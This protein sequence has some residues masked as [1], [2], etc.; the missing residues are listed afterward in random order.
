MV[1]FIIIFFFRKLIRLNSWR[2]F[3]LFPIFFLF[4]TFFP[5]I[6]RTSFKSYWRHNHIYFIRLLSC[7]Q[8][9]LQL[10]INIF[11][12]IHLFFVCDTSKSK[13]ILQYNAYLK[14]N[15]KRKKK[16]VFTYFVRTWISN[17]FSYF[18]ITRAFVVL[19]T[20]KRYHFLDCWLLTH[21]FI[22]SLNA[23]FNKSRKMR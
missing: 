10:V 12:S 3:L 9:A 19:Y 18:I 15:K 5:R 7:Y 6:K 20:Y 22:K 4:F 13:D 14:V 17:S 16:I 1:N 8:P 21:F 2:N 11:F 23:L